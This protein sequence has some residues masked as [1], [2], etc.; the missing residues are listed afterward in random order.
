MP[1]PNARSRA[2]TQ[3]SKL[4]RELFRGY[5]IPPSSLHQALQDAAI[6]EGWTPPWEREEQNAKKKI[7]GKKSGISRQ[8]LAQIR[9][10]FLTLARMRVS[11][12]HRR[13]PY[14]GASLAA[15]TREYHALL[16]KDVGDPD[17]L[18]AGLHSALSPTDRISL[19]RAS[20]DTLL[21]DLK[22]IRRLNSIRR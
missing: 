20:D 6:L 16:A 22:I 4:L 19:R 15:V 2:N 17:P 14:S 3:P 9:R 1:P 7:A 18:I 5:P 12:E 8:G 10:S 21:K 11:P 13:T